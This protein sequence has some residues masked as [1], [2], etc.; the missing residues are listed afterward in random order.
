M[1]HIPVR[2]H[3]CL[4]AVWACTRLGAC[5]L[6]VCRDPANQLKRVDHKRVRLCLSVPT[7]VCARACPCVVRVFVAGGNYAHRGPVYTR[8][9]PRSGDTCALHDL[10][11]NRHACTPPPHGCLWAL[12]HHESIWV[13]LSGVVAAEL[14]LCATRHPPLC[15]RCYHPHCR[16]RWC[17]LSLYFSMAQNDGPGEPTAAKSRFGYGL[18]RHMPVGCQ[19]VSEVEV[20]K[21]SKTLSSP[22]P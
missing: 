20:T 5:F 14:M 10:F 3:V 7:S 16:A 13:V 17:V 6:F 8:G 21:T 15:W 19:R 18:R 2:A 1:F 12:F 22:S 9:C 4:C 11:L